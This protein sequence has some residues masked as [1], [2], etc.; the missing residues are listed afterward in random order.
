MRHNLK[1]IEMKKLALLFVAV[2][3]AGVT[4]CSKD[5]DSSSASLEGK[6]EYSKEGGIIQGQEV[7]SN[8]AH[9]AG[10]D[11]DFTQISATTIVNHEFS[12]DD[13]LESTYS[14]TYTRNGNTLT[15]TD[16]TDVFTVTILQLDN[17]TLKIKGE[18]FTEGGIT[19]SDVTVFTRR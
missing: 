18:E 11:K 1:N 16:G 2:L 15:F 4:S 3:A 14:E 13:C 10:C 17:T 8:Y 12:G 6:W 5:D 9:A 7:L 19:Y